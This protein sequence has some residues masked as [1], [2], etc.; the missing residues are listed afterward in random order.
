[1]AARVLITG[2]AGF[3][4]SNVARHLSAAGASLTLVTP[5]E[6][7]ALRALPAT[8][9]V[10]GRAEGQV[11]QALLREHDALI[12]L[13]STTNPRVGTITDELRQ[14]E[15]L[16]RLLERA[17][18]APG[19]RLLFCSSGGTIYRDAERPH[20]EDEPLEPRI[21]YAWGKVAAEGL[22]AYHGRAHGLSHLV[23]R[24]SNVYGPGQSIEKRQGVIVK[25]LTDLRDGRPTEV[26]GDGRAVRDYLFV[27]DLCRLIE[28]ALASP[29]TGAFNVGSGVGTSLLGLVDAIEAVTGRRPR[30]VHAPAE[31]GSP[32]ANVLDASAAREAF[33]WAPATS[34]Q[35]GIRATWEWV[36]GPR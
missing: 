33:G 10:V 20:R 34:L 27:A 25:L 24:C 29:R 15:D 31:A 16:A 3:L 13:A 12:H 17:R 6:A 2:A 32:G 19:L 26:W 1:M 4:G 11:D 14:L 21:P 36:A 22:L 18:A 7:P 8:R 9:L 35:E 30:L 28:A 5:R 23:L